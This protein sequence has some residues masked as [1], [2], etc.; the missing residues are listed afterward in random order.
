MH[1]SRKWTCLAAGNEAF[2]DSSAFSCLL[3]LM[4]WPLL[5]SRWE[6]TW[7]SESTRLKGWSLKLSKFPSELRPPQAEGGTHV[8]HLPGLL[9]VLA[10]TF[11]SSLM[12]LNPLPPLLVNGM[13]WQCPGSDNHTQGCLSHQSCCP[14]PDVDIPQLVQCIAGMN[15]GN[16]LLFLPGASGNSGR[17][18]KLR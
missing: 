16:N 9:P 15:R 10:C 11:A 3:A 1:K 18:E 2:L 14:S 8:C 7:P 17:M 4:L 6:R 12:M 13:A 5:R